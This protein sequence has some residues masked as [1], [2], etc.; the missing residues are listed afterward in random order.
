MRQYQEE[1]KIKQMKNADTP[2]LSVSRMREA[3]AQ[4]KAPYLVLSGNVKPGYDFSIVL[5][6]VSLCVASLTHGRKLSF[7]SPFLF[8]KKFIPNIYQ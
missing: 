5:F 1:L 8:L 4:L 6:F 2:S 7:A 3:Q